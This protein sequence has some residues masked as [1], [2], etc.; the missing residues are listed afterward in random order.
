MIN[1][2]KSFFNSPINKVPA[3][4]D[5]SYYN[6]LDGLRGLA[7]IIVVLSHIGEGTHW[8][9]FRGLI[10]VE[11]FFVLSGFLI[12]TLL[13]KEK[14]QTGKISLKNFYI[15]RVLRILPVAYL[16]LFALLLF[17][18]IFTLNIT[19]VAFI[20]SFLYLRNLPFIK[21]TSSDWYVGH[22]WTLTIEEQFYLIFP[23]LLV[24]NLNRYFK[25]ICSLILLVP[26]IEFFGYNKIGV[27]YSS[28]FI[29]LLTF[30]FINILGK[31]TISILIGSLLSV[32]IFKGILKNNTRK[33]PYF[34]SS[35]LLLL[36]I[37]L[38]T[39]LPDHVFGV[40]I[41]VIVFSSVVGFIIYLS[42]QSQ[43][44]L[45]KVLNNSI[46]KK[47]G[48][49]SYSIYIWQE[50]FTYMQPWAGHFKYGNSLYLN[51]PALFIVAYLSY[52]FYELKFLK[53]K[54]KFKS[55]G[56]NIDNKTL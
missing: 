47:I 23:F 52:H 1:K 17:N 43:G 13:I 51:I 20:S 16:Y 10:G 44:F 36:T 18:Y 48:V 24:T 30:I 56:Y 7:V 21:Q 25:I 4:L 19:R 37:I 2:I 27:F 32:M 28:H 46:L 33:I 39:I 54:E 22:F 11:I 49:L 31:G 40:N 8:P 12:T 6:G 50:I 41:G 45:S 42:I 38:H 14:I 29:H 55:V 34:L 3:L 26:I 35:F 5:K 9:Y 53:L 15:R